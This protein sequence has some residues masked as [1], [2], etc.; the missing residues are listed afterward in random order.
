[1]VP[2]IFFIQQSYPSYNSI[3][4]SFFHSFVL[5]LVLSSF[6]YI[7]L[8]V[9]WLSD[10]LVQNCQAHHASTARYTIILHQYIR[11]IIRCQCGSHDTIKQCGESPFAP[12]RHVFKLGEYRCQHIASFGFYLFGNDK[13]IIYPSYCTL[14]KVA[15]EFS[16]NNHW[17]RKD[18]N[19]QGPLY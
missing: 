17:Y 8:F 5:S 13:I 11:L 18:S 15:K 12:R 14:Y 19:N 6:I 4:L 10:D 2:M 7:C 16:I 1:M 9:N 3:F